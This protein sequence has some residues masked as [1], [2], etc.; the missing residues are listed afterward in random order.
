M[1]PNSHTSNQTALR[2]IVEAGAG[3]GKTTGLVARYIAALGQSTDKELKQ[4]Y[5]SATRPSAHASEVLALTFTNEAARQMQDRVLKALRDQGSS[6]EAR[7]V[8]EESQIS[9]Y[10]S[11]CLRLLQPHLRKLGYEG[12][13]LNPAFASH[14]RKEALLRAL[15]EYPEAGKVRK[16]MSLNT[17]IEL[18]LNY[19]F[20]P[21][22]SDPTQKI[23]RDYNEYR[24]VFEKFRNRE[25]SN[26][27][28]LLTELPS[29]EKKPKPNTWLHLYIEALRNPSTETVAAVK[30][31]VALKWIKEEHPEFYENLQCYREFF[32]NQYFDALLPEFVDQELEAQSELWKFLKWALPQSPKIFDFEAAEIEL[33]RL[34][35][36]ANAQGKRLI[37][38]PRVILVD[39][40]QDT[41]SR[42]YEILQLISDEQT[43]WYF[44][45][46]PKQSIYAFRGGDV[47]LFYKLRQELQRLD[48]DTN[49]RSQPQILRYVNTLQNDLFQPQINPED[50]PSQIL[51]WPEEKAA[52]AGSVNLHWLEDKTSTLKHT[53]DLLIQNKNQFESSSC[54][55][56]F[57]TWKKLYQFSDLLK[58]S[59]IRYRVAGSENPFHHILT[60]LFAQYLISLDNPSNQ[61]GF[62]ALERWSK[63]RDF[64]F[65]ELLSKEELAI[66]YQDASKSWSSSFQ[67]FCEISDIARFEGATAW[68]AAMERWLNKRIDEGF[69]SHF[70]RTQLAY[71]ILKNKS[72]LDGEDPYKVSPEDP[73]QPSLTLLTLHASKGL[74]F[75]H[76]Y[77]PELFERY[78]NK[79]QEG[80][81]TEEGEVM[82]RLDL[83]NEQGKKRKSLVLQIEKNNKDRIKDAEEKRL[84]YVALTRAIESI[85]II[86]HVPKDPSK[87]DPFALKVLD[88][89]QAS[90]SYW[91]RALWQIGDQ[92]TGD[93]NIIENTSTEA[94]EI[95][96]AAPWALPEDSKKTQLSEEFQRCGVSRY[97]KLL[98]SS[99]DES[100][101][102][103][104]SPFL[105]P[106]KSKSFDFA[107]QD[108]V[109]T[110]FHR[111]LELWNGNESELPD[112]ISQF[113]LPIQ[114]RLTKGALALRQIPDLKNYWEDLQ[115]QPERVQREFEIFLLSDSYRLSGFAD[116]AWFQSK[117]Q[118][119]IID[120]K[121]GSSLKRLCS[122]ERITKF[123][124][125]LDLYASAFAGSF[126]KISKIV[127]GIELSDNPLAEVII[128]EAYSQ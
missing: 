33:Y 67:K 91:H 124:K 34:L 28:A 43:E 72:G 61:E 7:S 29:R 18:S 101:D 16:A 122:Q 92:K 105:A 94:E 68:A 51:K 84:L 70:T 73:D 56:L 119:V 77:L 120:W 102:S 60:E 30:L 113:P 111:L 4:K 125:Q 75:K 8:Q 45:G 41:N 127:V 121:S 52:T 58:E 106:H 128:N 2:E 89:H 97:L 23:E 31:S 69:I 99:S 26:A 104:S 14:L 10:H 110:D 81:E 95:A 40:F 108:E 126:K 96:V 12:P 86:A 37:S 103:N 55:V 71:W 9:T 19:W 79:S 78:S 5:T 66:V 64:N 24:E 59:G 117:D 63:V 42:Q 27:E 35:K 114:K 22:E 25:L 13:L 115:S 11:F 76:I 87:K 90:H 46:D 21:L 74:E 85:D 98:D 17:L 47:S 62:W 83:R 20:H 44:V 93:W 48:K 54:A 65:T 50:P 6:L 57:K 49:Y 123:N 32:K 118:L 3:C 15:S 53:R 80:F 107:K 82:A 39:E 36:D 109:G 100:E 1:S 88:V 38:P 116:V 112:L